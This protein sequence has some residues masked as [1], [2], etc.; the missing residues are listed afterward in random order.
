M[1]DPLKNDKA[2][3]QRGKTLK[4]V[5][6]PPRIPINLRSKST[7]R[8]IS[9]MIYSESYKSPIKLIGRTAHD[10]IS[11]FPI[12]SP[13]RSRNSPPRYAKIRTHESVTNL[14]VK[15][16]INSEEKCELS[17]ELQ[18]YKRITR[19]LRIN[20]REQKQKFEKEREK[21]LKS[22]DSIIGL[23]NQRKNNLADSSIDHVLPSIHRKINSENKNI[24]TARLKKITYLFYSQIPYID[25][26][27]KYID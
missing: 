8:N 16:I 11:S 20:I 21:F 17:P 13:P 15:Q 12:N 9:K 27:K 25:Y 23:H 19:N 22:C 10:I 2:L 5:H 7:E 6:S 26:H 14:R 1:E 18:F 3:S 24:K 4:C